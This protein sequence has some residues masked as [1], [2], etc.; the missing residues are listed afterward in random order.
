MKYIDS[1]ERIAR[2]EDV[3]LA[4]RGERYDEV[5]CELNVDD[6]DW[7]GCWPLVDDEA[8]LTGDVIEC[9]ET[10]EYEIVDVINGVIVRHDGACDAMVEVQR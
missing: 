1:D 4:L 6:L 2:L 7:T 8:R 9:E 3:V 5:R 10:A